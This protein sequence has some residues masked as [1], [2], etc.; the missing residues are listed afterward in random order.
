[1][2]FDDA[3]KGQFPYEPGA[4]KIALPWNGDTANHPTIHCNRF[5]PEI[6]PFPLSDKDFYGPP[7]VDVGE[8]NIVIGVCGFKGHGKDTAAEILIKKYGFTRL[9]FA[10]G[11]KKVVS[12]M[13]HVPLW[14][15]HDPERKEWLHEPSGKTYRHWM[16]F[17]GT[18][19]GRQIW[20][21]VWVNWWKDE[22]SSK[23]LNRIVVTD[24][25]FWNEFGTIINGD[26]DHL[27]LRIRNPGIAAS[28]D[29]HESER[30]ALTFPVN[31]EILNDGTKEELWDNVET[32][33]L[34]RWPRLW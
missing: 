13:L 18:E 14:W 31:S 10:D 5:E 8:R 20:G 29:M 17:L 4:D 32:L 3:D 27:T 7:A 21:D 15:L 26:W 19:V 6:E 12:E 30:H 16:Q 22:I 28:G 1:M 34:K 25:R 33:L 23:H 2:K 9:A 24:M 11:V